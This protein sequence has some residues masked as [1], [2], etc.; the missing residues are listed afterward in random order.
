MFRTE[1]ISLLISSSPISCSSDDLSSVLMDAIS[2]IVGWKARSVWPRDLAASARPCRIRGI[3]GEPLV[4]KGM[5]D[6]LA[7][8]GAENDECHHANHQGLGGSYAEEG[9]LHPESPVPRR[10]WGKGTESAAKS[11]SN[12]LHHECFWNTDAFNA[13]FMPQMCMK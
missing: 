3:P 12:A 13:K 11:C 1:S 9:G 10:T 4:R 6:G 7:Y 5:P 8:L 2:R